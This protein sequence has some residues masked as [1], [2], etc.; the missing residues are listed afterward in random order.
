MEGRNTVLQ[1]RYSE[2]AA[3]LML[4]WIFFS[5]LFTST[6][7]DVCLL[8]FSFFIFSFLQ[9]HWDGSKKLCDFAR[10]CQCEGL[11]ILTVY[12][13]STENWDRDPA[14]VET[15]ME[16]IVTYCDEILEKAVERQMKVQV[17]STETYRVS[18]SVTTIIT[19]K[20]L[21]LSLR[22]IFR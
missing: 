22:S 10:W 13:F 12:A 2:V 3:L 6:F 11:Q 16:I 8:P 18:S 1:P 15:L 7:L 20:S 17:L 5:Y 14:E 9:G 4:P 19:Y 21:F